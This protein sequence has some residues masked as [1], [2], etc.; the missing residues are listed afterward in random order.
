MTFNK[1][2]AFGGGNE[3]EECNKD[4]KFGKV[5]EGKPHL[6][7]LRRDVAGDIWLTY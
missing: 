6:T 7:F 3:L 2:D 1:F 4:E 5:H